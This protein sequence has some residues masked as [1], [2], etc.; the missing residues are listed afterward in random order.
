MNENVLKTIEVTEI[1]LGFYLLIEYKGIWAELILS[2]YTHTEFYCF[3]VCCCIFHSFFCVP[4]FTLFSVQRIAF[5]KYFIERY[6]YPFRRMTLFIIC[7]KHH[8]FCCFS[9][10]PKRAFRAFDIINIKGINFSNRWKDNHTGWNR[11]IFVCRTRFSCFLYFHFDLYSFY[12]CILFCF[13]I[14]YYGLH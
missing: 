6:I 7:S 4:F 13:I 1:N 8:G 14:D 10:V 11:F 3:V 5:H 2:I 12:F 9:F